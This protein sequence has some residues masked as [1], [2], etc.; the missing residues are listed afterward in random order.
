MVQG[1]G[2][3]CWRVGVWVSGCLGVGFF[4]FPVCVFF[5]FE[6]NFFFQKFEKFKKLPVEI[7]VFSF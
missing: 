6:E 5:F 3:V 7:L 1:V 2:V 4:L